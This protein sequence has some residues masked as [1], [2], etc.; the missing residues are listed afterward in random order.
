MNRKV[1]H[2]TYSSSLSSLCE[3]NSSFDTGMLRI[4]YTGKNRNGSSISK[5]VFEKC[6]ETMYNCPIVCNYDRDTDSIGGHDMELVSGKD[7]DLKIVN[8]TMPIGVIPESSKYSWE[9]VEEDDGTKHE[10]LCA[11][12]LIWKRQEA[13]QKIKNDGITKHSME[14]SIKDG[15]L[16]DG[17]FEIYDFEFTAFCLLG[18]DHEPCFE[19]SAMGLF[20]LDSLK[21]QM[22]EMMS[23]LK[24]TYSLI[25]PRSEVDDTNKN[26]TEGG[27][28]VL[29]EKIALAAEF[30][31]EI[32]S[33]EFSIEEMTV[34]DLRER[35]KAMIERAKKAAAE[36]DNSE[37]VT[38]DDSTKVVE[39]KFELNSQI[40]EEIGYAVG[41]V[42]VERPWGEMPRYHV[43]DHDADAM[44]VYCFDADDH[45]RL[46]G[47]SFSMNGDNVVVDFESKK[48]MK[49]SIVEFDQ[50]EQSMPLDAVFEQISMQFT[51]NDTKWSEKYKTVSDTI[52]TM[53]N[54][55]GSLRQFKADT[56]AAAAEVARNEIFAQFDDLSGVEEFEALRENCA[57]FDFAVLEEKCYAIRGRNS[58]VAKFTK[59]TETPKLKVDRAEP[60]EDLYG[61]L[62]EKY[63]P[64]V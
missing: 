40:C 27:E 20:S 62:F 26:P 7:G 13:Y 48:R 63:K 18:D 34:E 3:I 30:G 47:F 12:V 23:E 31:I 55:L 1:A 37:E 42:M 11:E 8:C 44:M 39:K 17:V 51:A 64:T 14:L 33:L 10:Y 46:Y 9:I 19:S 38:K 25:S 57:D 36:K 59:K 58:S 54:E 35:F 45:W 61:G 21:A 53:N 6:I 16:K 22:E 56:E 15:E 50:G 60:E 24:E 41:A 28:K 43:V 29:D 32:D 49:F 2:M 52:E 5:D 4:A